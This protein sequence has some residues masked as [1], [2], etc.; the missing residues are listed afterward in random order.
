MKKAFTLVELLVSVSIFAI[1]MLAATSAV[2]SIVAANNKTHAIKSVM[3]NLDFALESMARVMRVGYEYACGA[4]VPLGSTGDCSSGG[5]VFRFKANEDVDGDNDYNPSDLN[6]IIE[7]SLSGGQIMKKVYGDNTTSLPITAP[8]IHVTN[9]TFYLSGSAAGDLKQP[10]VTIVIQG[11][12]GTG[13]TQS[14]FNIE[15]TVT[16]RAIDS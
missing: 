3:T 16:Q 4:S 8:E 12:A 1:V 6:D 14:D 7:Y 5:T 10:K 15:T 2:F 13:D 9:L 11:Y